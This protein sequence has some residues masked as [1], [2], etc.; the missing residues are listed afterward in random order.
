LRDVAVDRRRQRYV[1]I[2][3]VRF[4]FRINVGHPV[5]KFTSCWNAGTR[6]V[7]AESKTE[8]ESFSEI[9]KNE[10]V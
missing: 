5:S 8:Y 3:I 10:K 6:Y 9:L 4:V 2:S 7:H 1:R